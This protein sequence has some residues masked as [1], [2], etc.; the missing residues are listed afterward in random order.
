MIHVPTTNLA[1]T[2]P[3]AAAGA[4]SG[5]TWFGRILRGRNP[6]RLAMASRG[7]RDFAPA[8][9]LLILGVLGLVA[10]TLAPSGKSGQYAVIAPPWYSTGQT[11]SLI[12][13]AGGR[14]AT[15]N[16]ASHIVIAHSDKAGFDFDLYRAGAWLVLDPMRVRGCGSA[17]VSH[18]KDAA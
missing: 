1:G 16:P 11:I 8:I 10:A 7:R 2:D 14:I 3:H 4:L 9:L 15:I 12:Q 6:D 13:D 5:R 17:P 18:S